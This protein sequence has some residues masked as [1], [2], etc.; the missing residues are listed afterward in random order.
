MCGIAG[1]AG[2][3][4]DSCF[5]LDALAH[6]G[7]DQ[8]GEWRSP[9]DKIWLGHCRLSILDLSMS[10]RQP[11]ECHDGRYIV[12]FNG[13]IY[14]FVELRRELQ[15][16]G[17]SFRT[18][19][20]TEIIGA[21]YDLWGEECLHRFDGM[22]AFALWD[23][24]QKKLWLSRDRFGKKPIYYFAEKNTLAFA[25]EV[26][27]LHRWL[28]SRAELD[29][30]VV[31]YICA[32]RFGWQGTERT[33]LK[34]V[35]SLP[36]GGSLWRSDEGLAVRQWYRLQ[37]GIVRVPR[38]FK[39]QAIALRDLIQDACRLRLRS[40]VPL[41]TCLSGGIDSA[42]ITAMVHQQITKATE[43][44][45][46][47]AYEAFCAGFPGTMLDETGGA[48]GLAKTLGVKL[49]VLPIQPPSADEILKAIRSM[50][51]PMHAMA[52]YPIWKLFEFIRAMG[53][54]V[55]LDGQGPDEMMGGYFETIQAAM[56]S[57]VK[58]IRPFWFRDV[59]RTYANL[60]ESGFL[61]RNT[62]ARRELRSLLKGPLRACRS[63]M[64]N[65]LHP[66]A[67]KSE[68]DL[69]FSQPV[70]PGVTPLT[71]DLYRQ[72]CQSQLPTIL[73][74]YDRCSM[75]HG[76]ECRMPFMDHR[77]IEYIFSLPEESLI[78]GGYTK[79]VLRDAI[80]GLVP[81]STRLNRTKIGFNA[82][83][84]EWFAGPLRELMHDMLAS[85]ECRESHYFNGRD[86]SEKFSLWLQNPQ[87]NSAWAYWPP[88]HFVLWKRQMDSLFDSLPIAMK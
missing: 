40:D 86:L 49:N 28:G 66:P 11:L 45:A 55:T 53:V 60:G 12:I 13:E 85:R 74:Q 52:F 61:S 78:G 31:R 82:P 16:H 23:T 65:A 4:Y 33:Y 70:P 84:V 20:D 59:Y 7:P 46:G 77:I 79:R 10:A 58:S 80:R 15:S 8:Q 25:S 37:P 81:D 47:G 21:A 35:H 54:K 63:W 67:A 51:G 14:N 17:Y 36:A 38:G 44:A 18:D 22:W 72:F 5:P 87:W 62:D 75:A 3:A 30:T 68:G 6:R 2:P 83:L 9:N 19:S 1:L 42:T 50:D 41:A 64:R 39:D 32:G 73:Q 26:Q 29:S 48:D 57:A 27:A 69:E 24:R 43:R 88:V 71:A 56:L 76:V 34:D